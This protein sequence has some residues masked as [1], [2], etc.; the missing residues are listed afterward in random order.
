MIG[1]HDGLALAH[2]VRQGR[3]SPVDLVEHAIRRIER[4]NPALNAV[5]T[6]MFEQARKAA[7]RPL[8]PG[9]FAGVPFLAK[10]LMLFIRGAP[11]SNGCR[12]MKQ[13]H[14]RPPMEC[15][16]AQAIREAGLLVLGKTNTSEFGTSPLTNPAAFGPT[17]NPWDRAF[18]SGGSSGGSAAAVAA[19]MVPLAS[20]SDGGG[21]IRI[22][23]SLCGLFGFKPS[24]NVNPYDSLDVWG[25]AVANNALTVTV[26][27]SAAYLDWTSTRRWTDDPD[28][29]AV[30]SFLTAAVT[31]PPPLRIAVST[32]APTGGDV[33]PACVEAVHHAAQILRDL[34]HQV[35]FVPLPYDGRDLLLSFLTV[36]MAF[37]CRDLH[38]TAQ[39]LGV[40][41]SKL[42]LEPQTRFMAELGLGVTADQQAQA[43][44]QWSRFATQMHDF[45]QYYPVLLTPV[46]ARARFHHGDFSPSTPQKLLMKVLG[47]LHLGRRMF[48]D[49]LR[50]QM[51]TDSVA[52]TPFTQIANATGQPAMSVPLYWTPDNRPVGVQFM[53]DHGQDTLLFQLAGQLEAANPW[54]DR[55]P[56]E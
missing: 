51:I 16:Q 12:G 55:V 33:D 20:A 43:L 6:P 24:R 27:D 37:T 19:R 30:D 31:P 35:D 54:R 32:D 4:L 14:V 13:R 44:R 56:A 11:L 29:P 34:G 2:M 36:V 47:G 7:A 45:H 42:A 41:L 52:Q 9:P 8:P 3:V 39:M 23:A 22:P 50:H 25:G 28:H 15:P 10:D 40:K 1:T 46:T 18:N 48:N 5:I 53:A 49:Q 38:V 21:S 26:R 17:C